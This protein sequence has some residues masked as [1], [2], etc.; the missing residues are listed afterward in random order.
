MVVGL[1][2]PAVCRPFVRVNLGLRCDVFVDNCRDDFAATIRDRERLYLR[3]LILCE[4]FQHAHDRLLLCA[5]TM[6]ALI[7][8]STVE[9]F[10]KFDRAAENAFRLLHRFADSMIQKPSGPIVDAQVAL[11]L[12]RRN[13]LLGVYKNRDGLKPSRERQMAFVEYRPSFG[14][15]LEPA[16]FLVALVEI[17]GRYAS[18]FYYAALI[19]RDLALGF[20]GLEFR[21]FIGAADGA[22]NAFRPA[23]GFEVG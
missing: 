20:V 18:G 16:G 12:L 5:Q 7:V 23:S 15:E 2:H 9:S 8:A 17:A 14:A 4:T 11:H 13:T 21:D 3:G 10:V 6:A 22:P 1:I 19:V